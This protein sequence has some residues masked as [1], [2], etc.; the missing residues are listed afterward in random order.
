MPK[1]PVVQAGDPVLY[2]IAKPLSKKDIA[3]QKVQALL[4]R[5]SAILQKEGFGV[6]IAAPQVGE[7][8]QIFVVGGKVFDTE[9]EGASVPPDK[10]FIN[11]ELIRVSKSKKEMA[12][13]CLSVRNTYGAVMRHEKASVKAL[14]E[15]GEAFIYHGSGLIGQIFQH[16][17]DHLNGILYIDKAIEVVD[18]EE[19]VELKTKRAAQKHD[20]A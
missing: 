18:D 11:P 15:K 17:V 20:R 14:N 19:W 9:E 1:D 12:E 10:I 13:G 2:K 5:M 4:K 7:S 3:S 6:A 16:E 8:L